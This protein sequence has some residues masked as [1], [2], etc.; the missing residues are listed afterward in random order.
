MPPEGIGWSRRTIRAAEAAERVRAEYLGWQGEWGWHSRFPP[1]SLS[2]LGSTY[3]LP[4]QGLVM[5]IFL[6]GATGY[7]GRH[8]SKRLQER[9][10]RLRGLTRRPEAAREL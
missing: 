1:L 7:V 2:Y 4:L 10:H 6:I 3:P 5:N 9:G 8:V